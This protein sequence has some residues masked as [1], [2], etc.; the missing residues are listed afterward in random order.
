MFLATYFLFQTATV[1]QQ[2]LRC[3]LIVPEIRG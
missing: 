2:L 3:F 1:L